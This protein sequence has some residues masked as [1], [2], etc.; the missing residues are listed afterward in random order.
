LCKLKQKNCSSK[1]LSSHGFFRKL[2]SW[3]KR[4]KYGIIFQKG[5]I[6]FM[7]YA[8]P[9]KV[10]ERLEEKLGK[11]TASVVTEALEESIRAAIEDSRDR[12]RITISE[13]LKKE[14]A[15]KYDLKLT[16]TELKKEID[17]VRK[18]IDLVRKDLKITTIILIA[19][20]V[21]LNQNSLE[22]IARLFGILK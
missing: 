12:L 19:V 1:A 10:Y 6:N 5:R 9:V 17:L 21:F 22:F 20:M 2:T 11:E 4:M 18:E 8:I 16:E 3:V 7:A 14:L 13:D 15:N